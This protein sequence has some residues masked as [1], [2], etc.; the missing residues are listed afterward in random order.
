MRINQA[1]GVPSA[2]VDQLEE[3]Q[4]YKSMFGDLAGSKD[5]PQRLIEKEEEISKLRSKLELQQ[6]SEAR[7]FQEL[8]TLGKAWQKLEEQNSRKVL[9]LVEKEDQIQKLLQ[10]VDRFDTRK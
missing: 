3:L 9:N 10:E 8:D 7:L 2:N 5:L 6:K 4:Q 1:N